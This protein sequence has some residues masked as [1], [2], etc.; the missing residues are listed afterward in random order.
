[1]PATDRKI[2][3]LEIL[4]YLDLAEEFLENANVLKKQNRFRGAI[5]DGYNALE[6]YAKR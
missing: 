4:G 5:D 1:M 6:L 3:R 2:K